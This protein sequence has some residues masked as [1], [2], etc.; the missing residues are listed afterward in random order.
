MT[1]QPSPSAPILLAQARHILEIQHTVLNIVE[2]DDLIDLFNAETGRSFFHDESCEMPVVLDVLGSVARPRIDHV[3]VG[4]TGRNYVAL[5]AREPVDITL[6]PCMVSIPAA[7]VPANGSVMTM[8]PA[9]FRDAR[10]KTLFLLVS[11][12]L[13]DLAQPPS[14][15]PTNVLL[16]RHPVEGLRRDAGARCS[17]TQSSIFLWYTGPGV[18][19]FRNLSEH[20]PR[21]FPCPARLCVSGHQF[22]GE[23]LHLIRKFLLLLCPP[24]KVFMTRAS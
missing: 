23:R 3:P 18:S 17:Q 15:L 4:H 10:E 6:T 9:P 20:I 22:F 14:M 24:G 5:L 13:D 2:S 12:V 1:R 8:A 16:V 7:S 19:L 11:A 21:E